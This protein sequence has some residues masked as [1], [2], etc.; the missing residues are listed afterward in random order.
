[1]P[2]VDLAREA[3]DVTRLRIS[4]LFVDGVVHAPNGAHPTSCDPDYP[5]DEAFQREYA[6]TA[7]EPDA[8]DAFRAEWL[9]LPDEETY[10]DKVAGRSEGGGR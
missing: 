6:L 10:R 3:G 5:R 7:R 9:S 8:W 2:T 1:M 4:R